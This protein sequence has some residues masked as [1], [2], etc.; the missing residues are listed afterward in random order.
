MK[1]GCGVIKT[2]R[3]AIEK[4]LRPDGS[5]GKM[6]DERRHLHGTNS[7]DANDRFGNLKCREIPPAV[8]ER[9]Q[10]GCGQ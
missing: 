3:A 10:S 9:R 7:T 4:R 5:V 2:L 8:P 1:C 6:A